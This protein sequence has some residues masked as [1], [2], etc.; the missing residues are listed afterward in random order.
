MGAAAEVVSG[1]DAV[2]CT[3]VCAR[4]A[5]EFPDV[6]EGVFRKVGTHR[7]PG[8]VL[9]VWEVAD[10]ARQPSFPLGIECHAV[11]VL[12]A[13]IDSGPDHEHGRLRQLFV[14]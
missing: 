4:V 9:L 10:G 7:V 2:T 3:G 13:D 12:L 11:V 1:A 8:A 14:L 6:C 5:V